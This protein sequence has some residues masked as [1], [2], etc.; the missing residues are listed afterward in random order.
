M[1][2]GACAKAFLLVSGGVK[3]APIKLKGGIICWCSFREGC[4]IDIGV[5]YAIGRPVL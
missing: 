4:N 2:W 5:C 1:T 3:G